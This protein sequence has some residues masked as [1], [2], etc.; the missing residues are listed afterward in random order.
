MPAPLYESV[1]TG[2]GGWINGHHYYWASIKESSPTNLFPDY[3]PNPEMY[4]RYLTNIGFN[5][6]VKTVEKTYRYTQEL[7]RLNERTAIEKWSNE[8]FDS[9]P[10]YHWRTH[11]I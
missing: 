1:K 3:H 8:L 7:H 5:L 9:N 2:T 4:L 11:L 6:N 10:N